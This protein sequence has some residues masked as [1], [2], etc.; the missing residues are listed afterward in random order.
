[1]VNDLA[2]PLPEIVSFPGAVSDPTKIGAYDDGNGVSIGSGRIEFKFDATDEGGSTADAI[3]DVTG[4]SIEAGDHGRIFLK[5]N[6]IAPNSSGQLFLE[7]PEALIAINQQTLPFIPGAHQRLTDRGAWSD[8][9]GY[10]AGDCV[11]HVDPFGTS[12]VLLWVCVV[13]SITADPGTPDVEPNHFSDI[14][15]LVPQDVPMALCGDGTLP[16]PNANNT[17]GAPGSWYYRNHAGAAQAFFKASAAD[18][19]WT[20]VTLP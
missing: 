15:K 14:W 4:I 1:M 3:F 16:A 11:Y 17:P 18:G 5:M 6:T 19:G 2:A 9:S 7:G 8:A 20:A 10:I 12:T 13:T